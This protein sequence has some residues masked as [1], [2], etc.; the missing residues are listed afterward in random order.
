M[1][2][3]IEDIKNKFEKLPEDLKWAIMGA[4]I[5]EKLMQI[6]T[7]HGL[8]IRQIGQLSLETHAVML[9]F[10]H[11]DAFGDSIKA[12][13][14]LPDDKVKLITQSVNEKIIKGVRE[15][16]VE[17]RGGVMPVV[18]NPPKLPK[19][20]TE[21][22]VETQSSITEEDKLE[23]KIVKEDKK[24]AS[25]VIANKLVNTVAANTVK[26]NYTLNNISKGESEPKK[27]DPYRMPID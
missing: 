22:A 20:E 1:E 19:Q 15:K 12:S 26:T 14:G 4:N 27:L 25:G 8:N 10:V 24:I 9:G 5:D 13:L 6:G 21:Q 18:E 3:S 23:E 16:L 7:A 17:L 11:P 2:L